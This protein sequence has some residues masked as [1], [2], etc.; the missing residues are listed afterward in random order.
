MLDKSNSFIVE[1]Q[2]LS[3]INNWDTRCHWGIC[4]RTGFIQ[5][6]REAIEL[7]EFS[8][9]GIHYPESYPYRIMAETTINWFKPE[10]FNGLEVVDLRMFF[11]K[12]EIPQPEDYFD[13]NPTR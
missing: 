11:L 13:D 12:S 9:K 2:Y 1:W 5:N 7:L 8:N 10:V 4:Y 3:L 6:G